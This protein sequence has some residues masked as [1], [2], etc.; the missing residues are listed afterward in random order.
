MKMLPS[1]FFMLCTNDTEPECLEKNLF[2]DKESWMPHLKS[3]KKGDIGFLLNISKKQLLGVFIAES[4]AQ[5]NIMPEVWNGKFPAQIKVRLIG[6]LK[7]IGNAMASLG[8][9]TGYREIRREPHPYQV[10]PQKT[11]GPEITEKVLQLFGIDPQK[12]LKELEQ[13]QGIGFFPEY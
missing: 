12:F 9:I 11:Y 2:G 5:M 10:P 6:E 3:I 8:K 1:C 13:S 4:E 7:K